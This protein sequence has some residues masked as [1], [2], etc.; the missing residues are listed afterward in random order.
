MGGYTKVFFSIFFNHRPFQTANCASRTLEM[1]S[2][3]V[4]YLS[5]AK[6]FGSPKSTIR[7]VL[8]N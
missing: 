6:A 3:T 5:K 7:I 4:A 2:F 8:I 1:I